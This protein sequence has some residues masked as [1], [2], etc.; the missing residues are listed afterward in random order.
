MAK[1]QQK[2]QFTCQQVHAMAP[3]VVEILRG[4]RDAHLELRFAEAALKRFEREL[5]LQTAPMKRADYQTRSD[6]T[7]ARGTAQR[8]FDSVFDELADLGAD[9][10][11]GSNRAIFIESGDPKHAYYVDWIIPDG[12]TARIDRYLID[13]GW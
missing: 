11:A 2:K 9:W 4:L 7:E 5:S 10:D 13:K 1:Q 12:G 8:K 6:L 3:L